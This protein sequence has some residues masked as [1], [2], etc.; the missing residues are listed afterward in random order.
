MILLNVI[1][2][3]ENHKTFQKYYLHKTKQNHAQ[4]LTNCYS[5]HSRNTVVVSFE[6]VEFWP[7]MLLF[8]THHLWNS[9]TEMTLLHI[10]RCPT[11]I[12]TSSTLI[13]SYCI[14][15]TAKVKPV[16]KS[17]DQNLQGATLIFI[18]SKKINIFTT[19]PKNKTKREN[20]LAPCPHPLTAL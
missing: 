20:L 9:T 16:L 17:L 4:F 12:V 15:V 18:F 14:S 3:R 1:L 6:C 11:N 7:K 5:L 10:T 2:R 13:S 8:R 19:F